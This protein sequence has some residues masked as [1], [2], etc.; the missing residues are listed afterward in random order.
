VR[1]S[2]IEFSREIPSMPKIILPERREMSLRARE[3]RKKT[4]PAEA[5]LWKVLRHR[6]LRSLKFRRQF[7]IGNFIADFCCH[8]LWIVVELDGA[9]HD[10]STQAAHDR[11]RDWYL[12]WRGYTV[13]RFL[14]ERVFDDPE[15]VLEEVF[16][17]AWKQGWVP[18]TE[19]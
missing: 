11:N 6:R 13:L 18:P 1:F 7:P 4:T 17:A 5:A 19:T 8:E 14:N 9:V 3:L 15:G 10:A 12:Q 2:G 16:Q